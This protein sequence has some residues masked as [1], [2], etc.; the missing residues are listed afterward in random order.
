GDIRERM[1]ASLGET[2]A[3]TEAA[4][5]F[6]RGETTAQPTRGIDLPALVASGCDDLSDL[7]QNGSCAAG[8][9][10]GHRSQHVGLP[11]PIRN[12][13]ENAVHY[14]EQARVS[15]RRGQK[16]VDILVEDR[17]PG[18]PEDMRES[19]FAPLFSDWSNPAIGKR[20]A[21]AW[22]SASLAPWR[23]STAATCLL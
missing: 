13:V 3:T 20:A 15:I 17:G 23:V 5:D 18:I 8:Q 6:A 14:G 9:R 21:S 1:L 4:L 19:V 11:L 10:A 2:D 22:V 12:V 7:S 16:T